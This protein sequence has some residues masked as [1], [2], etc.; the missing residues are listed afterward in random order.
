MRDRLSRQVFIEKTT[1]V[2]VPG[3]RGITMK[4]IRLFVFVMSIALTGYGAGYDCSTNPFTDGTQGQIF[5][6]TGMGMFV[7]RPV[8]WK[9]TDKRP[10]IFMIYGGGFNVNCAYQFN[11]LIKYYTGSGY[12]CIVVNYTLR[13]IPQAIRDC[14]AAIRWVRSRAA[15]YGIDPDKVI[16][17]GSS[18]GGLLA[19]AVAV[20]TKIDDP[21]PFTVSCIPNLCLLLWPVTDVTTGAGKDLVWWGWNDATARADCSPALNLNDAAPPTLVM[22]GETDASFAPQG[23]AFYNAA[24]SFDFDCVLKTMKGQGHDFGYRM[25]DTTRA[26]PGEDSV[27]AWSTA[28]LDKHNMTVNALPVDIDMAVVPVDKAVRHERSAELYDVAGHTIRRIEKN[29]R[30]CKGILIVKSFDRIS[31]HVR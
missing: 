23:R 17:M 8:N 7:H 14:K 21:G 5:Y 30:Y 10:V 6:K 1:G 20:C 22:I 19:S 24:Q 28:F 13:N 11:P 9:T 31:L 29:T 25:T 15:V 4:L 12:V 18:A 16:T 27:K 26:T 3:T 2:R